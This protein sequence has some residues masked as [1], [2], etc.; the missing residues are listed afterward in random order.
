M[1][2]GLFLDKK[3]T[4][5]HRSTRSVSSLP[6]ELQNLSL[7]GPNLYGSSTPTT[8]PAKDDSHLIRPQPSWMTG[9]PPAQSSPM[10]SSNNTNSSSNSS[11]NSSN[12]Y[13]MNQTPSPSQQQQQQR[14]AN[15]HH[16]RSVS[17]LSMTIPPADPIQTG[18]IPTM[19]PSSL[20]AAPTNQLAHSQQYQHHHTP[21]R[22]H[23]HPLHHQRP[24]Q[25][26][27][28]HLSHRRAISA[29][30]VDHMIQPS[31]SSAASNAPPVPPLPFYHRAHSNSPPEDYLSLNTTKPQP[32]DTFMD[33]PRIKQESIV[34]STTTTS[35][36]PSTIA[37]V[38]TPSL[39]TSS[40]H[41][42]TSIPAPP[43][44]AMTPT[45]PLHESAGTNVSSYTMVNGMELPRDSVTGRY[46][47][48]YFCIIL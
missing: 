48:P 43:P 18:F 30:T 41:A 20:S 12:P 21:H 13:N 32:M 11:S 44:T 38:S 27:Q 22:L 33:R 15:T 23:H 47:C 42:L 31:S 39:S 46:L 1:C 36:P 3:F 14:S 8:T 17:D 4:R 24:H 29:T 26:H 2:F 5:G 37:P 35:P 7:N 28:R 10:I 16:Q 40:T 45:P 19:Q 6:S 25:H 34:S 9:P